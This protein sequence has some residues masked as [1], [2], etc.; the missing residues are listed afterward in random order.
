MNFKIIKNL[1][2]SISPSFCDLSCQN[3]L[4][5][6]LMLMKFNRKQP[7]FRTRSHMIPVLNEMAKKYRRSQS[8]EKVHDRN[9]ESTEK[10]REAGYE[11]FKA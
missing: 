2:L 4:G 1:F 10:K 9:T 8:C 11:P 6:N 5:N 7:Q 3:R